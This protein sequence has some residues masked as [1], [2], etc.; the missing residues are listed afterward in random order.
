[1]SETSTSLLKRVQS[2]S[3]GE[4][5][6]RLVEVYTPLIR[7]WLGRWSHLNHD[8]DDLVQEVMA[9]VVRKLPEFRRQPRPGAFRCW[10][11]TITVNCLRAHWRA[12]Q[13]RPT[14]VGDTD[15]IQLLEQLEDPA[16]GLSR[17]WDEE[18]DRH[19]F[20]RL[21][22]IVRPHFEPAT[23]DAFRLVALEGKSP[24]EAAAELELTVNAVFIAKSRV[25]RRLRQE[26]VG[27][28]E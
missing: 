11:R 10:L 7:G 22:E 14:V 24:D 20:Q 28:I 18:H 15:F 12:C 3:D 21:L 26:G 6:N 27:L 8:A 1:M 4:S 2:G 25:L 16:S 17:Q 19:V 5:W 13:S 23:W 9:V